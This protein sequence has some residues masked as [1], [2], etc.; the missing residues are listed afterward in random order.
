MF[1]KEFSTDCQL[2]VLSDKIEEINK[3]DQ[4]LTF[5]DDIK[6]YVPNHDKMIEPLPPYQVTQQNCFSCS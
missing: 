5:S 1:I 3:E 6:K 2:K 4:I